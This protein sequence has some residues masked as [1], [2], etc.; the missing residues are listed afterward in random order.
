M[1]KKIACLLIIFLLILIGVLFTKSNLFRK[2]TVV[3]LQ[4]NIVQKESNHFEE[5]NIVSNII[6]IPSIV[7]NIIKAT[8]QSKE[9][10]VKYQTIF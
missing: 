3:T 2:N 9:V 5:A 4:E 7:Q 10:L 1:I 6:D 8:L